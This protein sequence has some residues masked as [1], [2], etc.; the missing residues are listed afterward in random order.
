MRGFEPPTS[1]PPGLHANRAALHPEINVRK[2]YDDSLKKVK[3]GFFEIRDGKKLGW[4][5]G[6]RA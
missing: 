3:D 4:S 1:S 2:C 6:R 5:F